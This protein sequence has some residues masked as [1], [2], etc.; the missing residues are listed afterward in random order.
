MYVLAKFL[1]ALISIPLLVW[2]F[3]ITFSDRYF[4]SWQNTVWR[5]PGDKQWSPENVKFNRYARGLRAILTGAVLLY[6]ALFFN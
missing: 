2:G 3:M 5:E 1:F 4:S 6:I